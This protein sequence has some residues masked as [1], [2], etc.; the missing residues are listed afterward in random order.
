MTITKVYCDH[1][2]KILDNMSDYID[3]SF[4]VCHKSHNVDL[5]TECFEKLD[6]VIKEFCGNQK[7]IEANKCTQSNDYLNGVYSRD[8][9]TNG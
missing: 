1:C 9:K 2:G 5:C 3:L 7:A 6:Y 4:E 8:V